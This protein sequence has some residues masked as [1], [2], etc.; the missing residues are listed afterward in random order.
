MC[1]IETYLAR[2]WLA[3]YQKGVPA[4]VEVPAQVGASVVRRGH[5]ARARPPGGGVL[6]PLDQLPRAAR[7]HRP[8][9]RALAGARREEGRTGRA[10]PAQQP[11]IHHRLLRGAQVR[12]DRHADQPGLHQPRSALPARGQ[13]RARH[14]L[15]GHPL[16]ESRE[17]GRRARPGGGHQR[18]RIPAGAEA[19]VR[20]EGRGA[21]GK[22]A[23]A[24]GPA[25]EVSGAAAAGCDRSARPTSP[26]CLIPAAPPAI[27]R[28]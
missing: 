7:G 19:A 26:R 28:A 9:R 21:A 15:P 12:R 11:A 25:E 17:I 24:A 5:R 4:S 10:L 22:R 6:R 3:H 27:R 14:R 8:L 16:R 20:Q 18:Q 2:P 1:A 13:R 23:L